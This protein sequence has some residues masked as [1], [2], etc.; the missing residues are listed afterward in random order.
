MS[1]AATEAFEQNRQRL[2]AIAYRMLGSVHEAEDVVQDAY[3]RWHGLAHDT[4]DDP[5][6]YLARIVTRLAL[7]RLKAA[8]RTRESYVGPWL[9]EPIAEAAGYTAAPADAVASDV[10]FALMLALERLSPLERAAFLLH[11]VFE[12]DFDEVAQ[13]LGRSSA[14]C[15]Q[16]ASRARANVRAERP[17]FSVDP[18]ETDRVADAFFAAARSGDTAALQSLLA[19][20]VTLHTDGGGRVSAALNVIFGA[21]RVS[22]FFAGLARKRDHA[23]PRFAMRLQLNGQPGVLTVEDDGHRQTLAVEIEGGR[24]TAVYVTR[25]P[26]KLRHLDG[27]FPETASDAE[28]AL[29]SK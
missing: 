7:D 24:V 15:R 27:W 21:D 5:K 9:P 28:I 22:R 13:V 6:A 20:E 19:E 16:L 14:A 2:G 8:R 12:V 1:D 10:S 4:V 11:D 29:Q 18:A 17:R 23:P 26:D 25:N 3:L